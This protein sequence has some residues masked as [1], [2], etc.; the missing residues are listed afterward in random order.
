[1]RVIDGM[2]RLRA[3]IA[4]G[5][6]TIE[7]R[8]FDGNEDSTF[9]LAVEANIT[10]GLP[11]SLADREAAAARILATHPERSDRAIGASTGLNPK[12]VN[13]IRRRSTDEPQSSSARIGRD[14]RV[15]PLSSTNGRQLAGEMLATRPDRP[16][17]EVAK[18]AG[19]SLGTAHDVRERLRRGDDPV[20]A[21]QRGE[22]AQPVARKVAGPARSTV[23]SLATVQD[24]LFMLQNLKRDPSIRFNAGGRRLLKW[25]DGHVTGLDEWDCLAETVPPHSMEAVAKLARGCAESWLKFAEQLERRGRSSA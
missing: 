4:R 2:H 10:H 13:A 19:I 18:S 24:R 25:L 20:P 22:R 5:A 21:R 7:V 8:F 12:T 17:R 1:M 15:R 6:E 14:G 16:L 3:A 23:T 11:L 9:T